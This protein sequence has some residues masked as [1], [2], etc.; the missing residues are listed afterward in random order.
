VVADHTLVFEDGEH[1]RLLD[2]AEGGAYVEFFVKPLFV[3]PMIETFIFFFFEDIIARVGMYNHLDYLVSV[4][5]VVL[6]IAAAQRVVGTPIAVLAVVMLAYAHM[7]PYMPGGFL[8]HRGFSIE[9]IF[10]HSFLSIEGVFGIPITISATFIYLYLMPGVILRKTGLEEYFTNMAVSMT[11]WMVRGTTKIGILTS[12]FSGMIIGSSVANTVGNGAFTIPMTKRSGYKPPFAA[13]VEA[14]SSTGSQITPPIM[15]AAA[16][17]MIEFTGLSYYQ[18]IKA[19]AIP[20]L[21]FLH[22]GL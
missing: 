7:G 6:V 15:G 20:A 19:A 11:G 5:G 18:I 10:S 1:L 21:L 4:L 16:F 12:I 9:R 17:L 3:S 22:P 13:A 8:S 2:I 14:A